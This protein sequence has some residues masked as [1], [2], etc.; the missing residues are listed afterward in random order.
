MVNVL[1]EALAKLETV[2]ET[3]VEAVENSPMQR[4][5]VIVFE[6]ATIGT[7]LI[8][9]VIV[10]VVQGSTNVVIAQV[11]IQDGIRI[12]VNNYFTLYN[13]TFSHFF[14]SL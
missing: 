3:A 12:T 11:A 14:K 1:G 6:L 5:A 8:V 7:T 4:P 9:M 10:L 2:C 13:N